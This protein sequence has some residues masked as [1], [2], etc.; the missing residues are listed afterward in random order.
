MMSFIYW[1]KIMADQNKEEI[2][3]FSEKKKFA[4]SRPSLKEILKEEGKVIT[5]RCMIQPRNK[6]T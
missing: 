2:N 3:L 4:T 1:E 6:K 5:G